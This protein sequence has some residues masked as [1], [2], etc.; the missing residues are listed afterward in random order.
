LD[1]TEKKY[2]ETVEE[3]M[4]IGTDPTIGRSRVKGTKIKIIE[5]LGKNDTYK[6]E[7]YVG[8]NYIEVQTTLEKVYK[9]KVNIEKKEIDI[10]KD[11]DLQ[12]I[13]EQDLKPGTEVI[14]SED[15]PTTITLYIPDAYEQYPDFVGEG[16]SL[17][18]IQEFADKYE[19]VLDIKYT[20][21]NEYP[22]GTI[23][24]QSRT[25]KIVNGASLTITV[26]KEVETVVDDTKPEEQEE[27]E[28]TEETE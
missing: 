13:I 12:L 22:A 27:E 9:M 19:L 21:S 7:N 28:T 10:K 1:E 20:E 2:S 24:K 5:S 15:N 8:K 23:I 14:I 4:V 11:M 18:Q 26:T 25:G 17:D 16:W 3:G 6:I